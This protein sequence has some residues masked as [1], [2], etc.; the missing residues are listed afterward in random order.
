[1]VFE[2]FGT[3]DITILTSCC[4]FQ[5]SIY[6]YRERLQKTSR[7]GDNWASC[8]WCLMHLHGDVE[9]REGAFNVDD[10]VA[11]E[12]TFGRQE[13]FAACDEPLVDE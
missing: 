13:G 9:H 1:M 10:T 3:G 4:V 6:P 8:P 12:L 11:D 5:F 7:T 2:A